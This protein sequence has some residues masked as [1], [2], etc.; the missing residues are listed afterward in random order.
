MQFVVQLRIRLS[1]QVEGDHVV[2]PPRLVFPLLHQTCFDS[3]RLERKIS[4]HVVAAVSGAS[5]PAGTN[6]KGDHDSSTQWP[7]LLARP[8]ASPTG[9]DIN[10]L[11][12]FK[13]Q[14][15]SQPAQPACNERL[16]SRTIFLRKPGIGYLQPFSLHK[17][18][19]QVLRFLQNAKVPNKK[20][21]MMVQC[22]SQFFWCRTSSAARSSGTKAQKKVR[23]G[24][25]EVAAGETVG[26]ALVLRRAADGATAGR[27]DSCS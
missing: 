27:T 17:T 26:G 11:P 22:V 16:I 9:P 25:S 1:D 5:S 12:A 19:K 24:A 7:L 23:D 13:R 2:F 10:M 18:E 20:R 21:K 14:G 4:A 3:D 6:P 15:E 8:S